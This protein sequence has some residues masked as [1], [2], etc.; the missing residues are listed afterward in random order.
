MQTCSKDQMFTGK[1][2]L[3]NKL[4]QQQLV[5]WTVANIMINV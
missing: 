3:Q 4:P 1:T 5:R 2:W